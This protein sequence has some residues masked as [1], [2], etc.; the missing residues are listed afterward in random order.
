MNEQKI[1]MNYAINDVIQHAI[2]KLQMESGTQ[3]HD[4]EMGEITSTHSF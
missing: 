2:K 1:F 4:V 3:W